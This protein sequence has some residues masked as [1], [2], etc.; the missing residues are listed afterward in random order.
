VLQTSECLTNLPILDDTLYES[1]PTG[2]SSTEYSKYIDPS[3]I[4]LQGHESQSCFLPEIGQ[5]TGGV[6]TQDAQSQFSP[7]FLPN[8]VQQSLPA[9]SSTMPS[10]EQALIFY[11]SPPSVPSSADSAILSASLSDNSRA[12]N[13]TPHR[14]REISSTP[15]SLRH[16]QHVKRR[17]RQDVSRC[18]HCE[19]NFSHP[20][21][22]T[23]HLGNGRAAPS[24]SALKATGSQEK[25]FACTC[26]K[27]AYPRKDSLQR[28][29]NRENTR[30]KQ[31]QHRCRTCN[32]CRCTC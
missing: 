3:L 7:N 25:P 9:P 20:K 4:T 23:R 32:C 29:M 12:S 6:L 18:Q 2:A 13:D 8:V 17:N 19:T 28:H 30:E 24:C 11:P 26:H 14:K 10:L 16:R 31:Q 21:D 22:L 5:S 1:A 15:K 27:A